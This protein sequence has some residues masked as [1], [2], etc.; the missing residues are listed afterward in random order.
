MEN[1]DYNIVPLDYGNQI[2]GEFGGD[3]YAANLAID[4]D[5]QAWV[6]FGHF[7]RVQLRSNYGHSSYHSGTIRLEKR[8][9]N[10]GLNL[11]TFYTLA[12][13]ISS[14][15]SDNSGSGAD[16][17]N[18]RALEK[19]LA[20]FDRRH[21]G[22]ITVLYELP[23]GQGKPFLSRGGIVN[24]IFGGW[25][26]SAIQTMEAGNPRT[27]GVAGG[28]RYFDNAWR[29]SRRPD[30]VK[31]DPSLYSD[32]RPRVSNADNRFVQSESGQIIDPS[33]F[34]YPDAPYTLGNTGR[35][36]VT[37]GNLIWTQV[38]VLKSVYFTERVIAKIRWDMQNAIKH[39]NFNN[40]TNTWD[41]R[42][43]NVNF[44]KVTSDPRTASIGGQPLMNLTLSLQF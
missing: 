41:S 42:N 15:D 3:A 5:N 4:A 32:W 43:G 10:S 9:G 19:G 31:D 13:S 36:T 25:E 21:R 30:T 7:G 1:W 11:M 17:L 37:Q 39:Y 40:F 6:P 33:F 26:V 20:N 16:P 23:F 8:Y 14:Q 44:G 27:I 38:S 34:G 28:P 24:H 22:V 29:S 18:N 35:N 12:K 2:A